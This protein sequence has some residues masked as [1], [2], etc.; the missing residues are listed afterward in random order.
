MRT[1]RG[2]RLYVFSAVALATFVCLMMLAGILCNGFATADRVKAAREAEF[3]QADAGNLDQVKL[4]L[5]VAEN[6]TAAALEQYEKVH[7]ELTDFLSQHFADLLKVDAG[8]KIDQPPMNSA[9]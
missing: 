3:Q 7:G 6:A 1:N 9:G 8:S 5:A 4:N 2:R